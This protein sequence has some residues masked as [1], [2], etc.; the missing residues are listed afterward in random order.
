MPAEIAVTRTDHTPEELRELASRHR[1]RDCRARLRGIALMIGDGLPRAGTSRTAGAGVQ[2]MRDRVV[3][4]SARGIDG[5][6]DDARP[7]RPPRLDGAGTAAVAS[8]LEAGPGPGA[9]EPPRWTVADIR[10]RIRD[11]F[12]VRHT[13]EGARRLMPR[14]G[15]RHVPPRP[16]RPRADPGA[17]EGSRR[18]SSALA[19]AALPGGV[20][21]GDVPVLFQDGARIGRKGMLPRVRARKGTRP[22]I[23]R[24]HRH[25]YVHLFSAACPETGTAVGHVRARASTDGMGRHLRETGE[26]VPAGRHA[27]VVPGGAGRRRSR[28]LEVPDSVSPLRLP[29]Y[30]PEPDPVETLFPVLRHRHLPNRVSGSAGHV[31]NAVGEVWGGFTRRTG[32]ITRTTAGEWAGL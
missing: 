16:V 27:P 23:V 26:R 28:D 32:E 25:G 11:G 31:R 20:A 17:Q 5:L 6:R 8:W 12:G 15:V 14:I 10:E 22:R 24:D 2:T 18:D 3:R 30:S 7:G 9:G 19:T 1:Y 13:P 4:H 21:A 29:P